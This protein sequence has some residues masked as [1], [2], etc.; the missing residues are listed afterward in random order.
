MRMPYDA[1]SPRSQIGRWVWHQ[2]L[3]FNETG[4]TMVTL[5]FRFESNNDTGSV[6]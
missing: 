6:Y 2:V 1:P 3:G 4:K 5:K